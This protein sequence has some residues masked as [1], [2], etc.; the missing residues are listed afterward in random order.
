[1]PVKNYFDVNGG[2]QLTQELS[3]EKVKSLLVSVKREMDRETELFEADGVSKVVKDAKTGRHLLAAKER[4]LLMRIMAFQSNP[5]LCRLECPNRNSSD[6][7][8]ISMRRSSILACK[9]FSE[10]IY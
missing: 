9:D 10:L 3:F 7:P 5:V 8:A 2:F 6:A 1:M 4:D